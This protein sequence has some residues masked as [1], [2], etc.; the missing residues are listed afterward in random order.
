MKPHGAGSAMTRAAAG[1]AAERR[2]RSPDIVA[3]FQFGLRLD[4]LEPELTAPPLVV[5]H[6]L[7][8]DSTAMILGFVERGIRPDLILFADTGSEKRSTYAYLP[9]MNAYLAEVGF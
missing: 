5:S 1:A 2:R 6:G 4:P 9:V 8:V 3:D 7:G